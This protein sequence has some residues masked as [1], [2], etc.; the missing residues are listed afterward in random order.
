MSYFD[1][2]S[3][4]VYG[5]AKLVFLIFPKKSTFSN[6]LLFLKQVYR[7]SRYI[8][9]INVIEYYY[10]TKDEFVFLTLQGKLKLQ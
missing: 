5:E 1:T 8:K 7:V 9:Q 3:P 4:L 6:K 10:F 2:I